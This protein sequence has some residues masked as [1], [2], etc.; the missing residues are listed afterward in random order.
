MFAKI[1]VMTLILCTFVGTISATIETFDPSTGTGTIGPGG[2][3]D[4]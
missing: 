1:G 2:K 3:I 4:N